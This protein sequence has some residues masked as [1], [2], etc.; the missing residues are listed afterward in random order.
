MVHHQ[1]YVAFEI[2]FTSRQFFFFRDNWDLCVFV[3]AHYFFIK[4]H[5][6][7]QF[8]YMTLLCVWE[9]AKPSL[10]D[11]LANCFSFEFLLAKIDSC[12]N[13]HLKCVVIVVVGRPSSSVTIEFFCM[14]TSISRVKHKSTTYEFP[15]MS[16]RY[17]LSHVLSIEFPR[18]VPSREENGGGVGGVSSPSMHLMPNV[19]SIEPYIL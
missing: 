7:K 8:F 16:R 10:F 15:S 3:P 13:K 18:I 11:G 14:I 9:I 17:H 6:A 2:E 12:N 5:W 1:T 4:T 19:L